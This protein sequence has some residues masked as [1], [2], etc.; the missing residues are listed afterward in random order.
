MLAFIIHHLLCIYETEAKSLQYENCKTGCFL[1]N[2]LPL[3]SI[4]PTP[5]ENTAIISKILTGK[6]SMTTKQ[7]LVL[8]NGFLEFPSKGP[9]FTSLFLKEKYAFA[10]KDLI[11]TQ[12]LLVF[13]HSKTMQVFYT[14]AFCPH[15]DFP[16]F[17]PP[18]AFLT[19]V[20]MIY[21]FPCLFHIT[22]NCR[23][24]KST[25]YLPQN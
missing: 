10:L 12:P 1:L 16:N 25:H 11:S 20:F 18:V 14:R 2:L 8:H 19:N 3:L 4:L 22:A 23:L 6:T 24:E 5:A 17:P 7:L 15:S 13:Y 21:Y 9:S